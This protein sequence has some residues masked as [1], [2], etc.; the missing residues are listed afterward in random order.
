MEWERGCSCSVGWRCSAVQPAA[1]SPRRQNAANAAPDGLVARACGYCLPCSQEID[2]PKAFRAL[3]MH[4]QY[5]EDHQYM[6]KALYDDLGMPA[7]A[8]AGCEECVA[9]CPAGIDI[10]ERMKEAIAAFGSREVP[11]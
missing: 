8:C 2:I 10:P 7:D 6:G 11:A 3:Y 1:G 9:R 4:R 5:P